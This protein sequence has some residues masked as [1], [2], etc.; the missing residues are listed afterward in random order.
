VSYYAGV[1]RYSTLSRLSQIAEDQWGLVTRRQAEQAGV[2]R[3][4]LQRLAS[5]G[6]LERVA[7]GVYHLTGAPTPDHLDLRAAWLQLAPAVPAWERTPDQGVVSHRSAATLYGLS[8]LP[9]D[10]H[11]F[12]LPIRR[13][14]R[15][16]DVRLHQRP[17][18]P[19]VWISLHG[20][21]VTRPGRVA[22]DLLDDREDPEAVAHVIADAI[23][24]AYD[25]PRTFADSLAPHAARFGLRRGDGIGLLRWLLDLV[26][27]SNTPR[28]ME[29][30]RSHV[31]PSA[32]LRAA[33]AVNVAAAKRRA[34]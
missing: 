30:A 4:T 16:P 1:A 18:T 33:E 9:P 23:R 17:L 20:L 13:Q 10:R 26:G 24:E 5:E 21:P 27:D 31:D 22:S 6:V 11:D 3:A 19:G 7:H 14:S 8:H 12:T 2:S 34:G 32:A 15:R 28:Y 25:Y 29:E